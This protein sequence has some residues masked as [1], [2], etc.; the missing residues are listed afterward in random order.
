[1]KKAKEDQDCDGGGGGGVLSQERERQ[2]RFRL[3]LL[4]QKSRHDQSAV[5]SPEVKRHLQEFVLKKKRNTETSGPSGAAACSMGNLKLVP[6]AVAP[7][8][9]ILRK[10]ASESNLLKMKSPRLRA[11]AAT[12]PYA[13][14]SLHSHPPSI[15]EASAVNTTSSPPG[16]VKST[17]SSPPV[18]LCSPLE[19]AGLRQA[20]LVG[21]SPPRGENGSYIG[22][23]IS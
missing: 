23:G 18:E 10:T 14:S 15:P 12:G 19:L 16:S 4:K 20:G 1:M 5:A 21:A 9:P 6:T 22:S 8:Q 7:P 11:G 3:E 13:R 17:N 2:E